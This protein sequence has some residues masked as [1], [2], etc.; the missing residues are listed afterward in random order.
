MIRVKPINSDEVNVV[1]DLA[2][3]I[4]PV[5]YATIL[6]HEQINN[7]LDLIYSSENLQN[8]IQ[9]GHRFFGALLN[10]QPVGYASAY[11]DT[12]VL[13]LK[14]LYVLPELQGQ[15]AGKQLMNTIIA[16]FPLAK[17]LRLLVNRDNLPAQQFYMRQQFSQIDELPVKMGDFKF[18][19][20][21]FSKKL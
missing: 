21:V 16:A 1:I 6:T 14:K 11:Q 20:L 17:E 7:M 4:W 15:G 9:N 8:E 2:K 3:R 19:D 5:S 10:D 12:N 18:V 13:W